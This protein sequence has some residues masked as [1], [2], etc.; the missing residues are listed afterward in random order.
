MR[1]AVTALSL[2]EQEVANLRVVVKELKERPAES[3][4]DQ[5][6][7]ERA[8]LRAAQG[9]VA[10]L[11]QNFRNLQSEVARMRYEQ[12]GTEMPVATKF[13]IRI[14]PMLAS[15]TVVIAQIVM[16]ARRAPSSSSCVPNSIHSRVVYDTATVYISPCVLHTLDV[17]NRRA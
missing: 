5:V 4:N 17:K 11:S 8:Q 15:K 13:P 12:E 3:G 6:E 14:D 10:E 9:R 7:R 2:S 16:L 1:N